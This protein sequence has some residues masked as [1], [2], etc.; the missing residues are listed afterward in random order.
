MY[1]FVV[2]SNKVL[3]REELSCY[4]ETHKIKYEIV[5]EGKD[6]LIIDAKINPKIVNDLGG[7]IKIGEITSLDEIQPEGTYGISLHG[8][9]GNTAFKI[10]KMM[11]KQPEDRP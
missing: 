9:P 6:F 4:F 2:G 10:K 8:V 7:T 11:R 3:S 5:D 1:A